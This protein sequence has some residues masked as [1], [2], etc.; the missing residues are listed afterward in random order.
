MFVFSKQ[1]ML[2]FYRFQN[3]ASLEPRDAYHTG[4]PTIIVIGSLPR[5]SQIFVQIGSTRYDMENLMAAVSFCFHS[6]FALNASYPRTA[7]MIWYYIEKH[8]FKLEDSKSST[9]FSSIDDVHRLI[10][11]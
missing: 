11:D 5:I 1:S 2:F 7:E 6:F 4:Q 3:L 8:I 10:S 9:L